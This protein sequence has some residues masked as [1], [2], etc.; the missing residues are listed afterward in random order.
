MINKQ[1]MHALCIQIYD[2]W[3]DVKKLLAIYYDEGSDDVKKLV[4]E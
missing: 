4:T 2:Q 3:N 1:T